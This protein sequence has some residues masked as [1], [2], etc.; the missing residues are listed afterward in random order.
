MCVHTSEW[1]ENKVTYNKNNNSNGKRFFK[2]PDL[3]LCLLFFIILFFFFFFFAN[4]SYCHFHA[5]INQQTF[6]TLPSEIYLG[7]FRQKK[8]SPFDK[9]TKLTEDR[10][11]KKLYGFVTFSIF[12]RSR[13]PSISRSVTARSI[14]KNYN[15]I[16]FI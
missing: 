2:E 8:I 5:K 6:K 7:T 12:A 9:R 15:Q 10:G 11:N 13:R 4:S 1:V 16:I 3:V 14:L